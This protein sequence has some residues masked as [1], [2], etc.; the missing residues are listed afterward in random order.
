VSLLV[1]AA[2]SIFSQSAEESD[3]GGVATTWNRWALD[4]QTG[5]LAMWKSEDSAVVNMNIHI[6]AG[7]REASTA[8]TVRE[9]PGLA[10][11]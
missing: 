3:F 4:V 11:Q 7:L 5:D 10:R 2:T 8:T 6:L 1:E 9:R